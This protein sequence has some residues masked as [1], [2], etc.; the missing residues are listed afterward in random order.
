MVIARWGGVESFIMQSTAPICSRS[1]TVVCPADLLN[2]VLS[3][4][5]SSLSH[6]RDS[7]HHRLCSELIK[8]VTFWIPF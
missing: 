1:K 3:L 5:Y 4:P 8:W 2:M 7:M 6:L